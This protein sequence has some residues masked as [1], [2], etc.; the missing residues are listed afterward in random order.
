[1]RTSHKL[2]LTPDQQ[3]KTKPVAEQE[4]GYLEEI[5]ANPVLSKREKCKPEVKAVPPA[6]A[7]SFEDVVKKLRLSPTEFESSPWM[8]PN[9]QCNTE[10]GLRVPEE[11]V[12][13]FVV[14]RALGRHSFLRE[15]AVRF[16]VR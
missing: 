14:E 6:G 2:Q 12:E 3:I 1:L 13:R 16:A 15:N 11:F 7:S 8:A 5:R 4:V 9:S 10:C